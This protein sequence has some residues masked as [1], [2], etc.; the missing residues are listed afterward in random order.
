MRLTRRGI[1]LL[2]V[3]ALAFVLAQAHGARSLGVV[4][5]SGAVALVA[6]IWQVST[7]ET[8][9]LARE[10]SPE[11]TAGQRRPVRVSVS[12]TDTGQLGV[13]DH[14]SAGIRASPTGDGRADVDGQRADGGDSGGGSPPRED[15]WQFLRGLAG[16]IGAD[17]TAGVADAV[18][19]RVDA[20]GVGRGADVDAVSRGA[21]VDTSTTPTHW[22]TPGSTIAYDIR[23]QRRGEWTLGPAE[24][25]VRDLLGLFE[26]V[27]TLEET[28]TVLVFPRVRR[29]TPMASRRLYTTAAGAGG[30]EERTVFEALRE[31]DTGDSLRDVNWRISAKRD[32]LIV[33]EY[34]EGSTDDRVTIAA[35]TT[36]DHDD[37]MAEAAASFAIS[38]LDAGV[39]VELRL[40]GETVTAEP[41]EQRAV[42][43][44]LA[45]ARVEDATGAGSAAVGPPSADAD[46]HIDATTGDVSVRLGDTYTQFDALVGGS[47]TPAG[48]PGGTDQAWFSNTRAVIERRRNEYDDRP[49]QPV[50]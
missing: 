17:L 29:L 47:L 36:P 3:V 23:L 5:F 37:D 2:L 35:T 8:P 16:A 21:D 27:Y 7:A 48:P 20:G 28:D 9:T 24:I 18:R 34:A 32:E 15:G 30:G 25:V 12:S 49:G 43:V 40:P 46:V 26:E 22:T 50:S 38:L 6:A 42:L 44:S 1:A 31:Y 33:T 45:G 10:L 13:R 14:L 41:G 11:G 19:G 39:S 4:V